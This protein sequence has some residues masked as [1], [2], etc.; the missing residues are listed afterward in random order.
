MNDPRIIPVGAELPPLEGAPR[1]AEARGKKNEKKGVVGER[2]RAGDRFRTL[3]AFIDVTMAE[4]R[5]AERSV[6]F[7]L[8]RDT[9]PN[10]IARTGQSDLAA[11]AG[12]SE[13]AVRAAI[14]SLERRGL[15]E[16]VRRGRLHHG[17]S[18]YRVRAVAPLPP[19]AGSTLPLA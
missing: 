3:N 12:V 17:P 5:P 18:S 8:F 13:R 1:H 4:L 6:W 15:L 19:S 9:K 16:V 10:G 2:G 7:I 11:R 14:Q